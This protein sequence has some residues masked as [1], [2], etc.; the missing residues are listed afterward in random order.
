M[1][2]NAP[3]AG[4]RSCLNTPEFRPEGATP[5][6]IRHFPSL[7]FGNGRSRLC[8]GAA[9]RDE[10]PRVL[11]FT[12][13]TR[14]IS[15]WRLF[16]T[17]SF[18]T[19]SPLDRA[20]AFAAPALIGG[21]SGLRSEMAPGR[22]ACKRGSAYGQSRSRWGPRRARCTCFVLWVS[23]IRRLEPAGPTT[24]TRLPDIIKPA[25]LMRVSSAPGGRDPAFGS[26]R[27]MYERLLTVIVVAYP[28]TSNKNAFYD[29][30]PTRAPAHTTIASARTAPTFPST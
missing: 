14:A 19:A 18:T 21:R 20:A 23:E 29:L 12:F 3:Q 28:S 30:A 10:M 26:C 24:L 1:A 2:Y 25:A 6:P 27:S 9:H 7:E 8:Y 15:R 13:F 5:F 11:A 16:A 17:G 22:T 4:V